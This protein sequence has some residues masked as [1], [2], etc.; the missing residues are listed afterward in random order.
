MKKILLLVLSL[1]ISFACLCSTVIKENFDKFTNTVI[2]SVK[3]QT[4]NI[5]SINIPEVKKSS[6]LI[7]KQNDQ[8]AKN[9]EARKAYTIK[10]ENLVFELDRKNKIL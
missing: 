4:E 9:N 7:K 2:Q 1:T 5:N 3:K 6:E 10:K 8:I